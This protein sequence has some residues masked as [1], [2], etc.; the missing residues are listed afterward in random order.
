MKNGS[1]MFNVAVMASGIGTTFDNL[2][3]ISNK[4]L[5]NFKINGLFTD[6]SEVGCVDVA[7]KH[8]IMTVIIT[9]DNVW[10]LLPENTDL[11]VLAG[12]LKLLRI[13]F[14]WTRRVLN[15]H[16]SLLPKYGGK[17]FYGMRIHEAV[18]KSEDRDTGCTVHIVDNKYD[19]GTILEQEE[20]CV[21]NN[22]TP[23]TLQ[24]R[25][26]SLERKLYPRAINDYLQLLAPNPALT[27][28][29]DNYLKNLEDNYLKELDEDW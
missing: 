26:Q 10:D 18:I 4:G 16:P 17:G 15:I 9:P 6:K 27:V 19:T 24:E 23:I 22:D 12:W 1:K 25:V 13:P 2:A 20:I 8:D 29:V 7:I 28:A 14:Q 21:L 3:R 5:V 11:V